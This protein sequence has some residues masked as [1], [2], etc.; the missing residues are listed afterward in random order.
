MMKRKRRL[1][2]GLAVSVA[3]AMCGCG[4]GGSEGSAQE[5]RPQEGTEA[6]DGDAGSSGQAAGAESVFPPE[7]TVTIRAMMCQIP[8]VVELEQNTVFQ[9]LEAYA[10]VDFELPQSLLSSARGP[11]PPLPSK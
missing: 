8:G 7:E 3:I 10:N 9:D 2:L 5:S 1:A 11:R 6:Q 4:S